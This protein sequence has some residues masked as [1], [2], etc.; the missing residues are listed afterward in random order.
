M[1]DT[2]MKHNYSKALLQ[3]N[4]RCIRRNRKVFRKGQNQHQHSIL[5]CRNAFTIMKQLSGNLVKRAWKIKT[6]KRK[7][8]KETRKN[9]KDKKTKRQRDKL[10]RQKDIVWQ[11]CVD[12]GQSFLR[13]DFAFLCVRCTCA[14]PRHQNS[15]EKSHKWK[16]LDPAMQLQLQ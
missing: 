8:K 12:S 16:V 11:T 15:C 6:L 3:R 10:K 4:S 5:S 13:F 14:L 1:S 7:R 2:K 9:T